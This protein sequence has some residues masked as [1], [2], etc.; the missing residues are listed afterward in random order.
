MKP[1]YKNL[2]VNLGVMELIFIANFYQPDLQSLDASGEV[3]D[4][5]FADI[6]SL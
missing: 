3:T 4:T 5:A 1:T 6:K 2:H